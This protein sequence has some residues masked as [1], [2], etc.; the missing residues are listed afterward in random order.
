MPV[1]SPD[2]ST[3]P[4]A[5]PRPRRSKKKVPENKIPPNALQREFIAH[6]TAWVGAGTTVIHPMQGSQGEVQVVALGQRADG[7]VLLR[8]DRVPPFKGMPFRTAFRVAFPDFPCSIY[9][10]T[11]QWVPLAKPLKDVPPRKP[12]NSSK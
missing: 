9:L 4:S 2:G 5:L 6:M 3:V 10:L 12:R 7:Q 11:R 1:P 8:L